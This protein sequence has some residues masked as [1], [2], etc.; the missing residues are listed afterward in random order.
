MLIIQEKYSSDEIIN[1]IYPFFNNPFLKPAFSLLARKDVSDP[2][3]YETKL[4]IT[5]RP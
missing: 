2:S 5:R 4:I 1:K 3:S